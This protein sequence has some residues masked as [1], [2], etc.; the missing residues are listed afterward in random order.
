MNV[1]EFVQYYNY[2]SQLGATQGAQNPM[3]GT[4]PIIMGMQNPAPGTSPYPGYQ[5][6]TP[7]PAP[8]PAPAPNQIQYGGYI[9]DLPPKVDNVDT[10]QRVAA[11]RLAAH[12]GG[13]TYGE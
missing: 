11:D 1:A 2:L 10:G 9:F 3:G 8:A 6:V 7:A 12:Y 13:I 5:I 4:T